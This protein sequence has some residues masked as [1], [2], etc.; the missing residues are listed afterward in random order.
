MARMIIKHLVKMRL[1]RLLAHL[2]G[3]FS[4]AC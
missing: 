3:T 4:V 2:H 1:A